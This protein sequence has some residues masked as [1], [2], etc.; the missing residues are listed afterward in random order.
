MRHK[1]GLIYAWFIRTM[2]YFLPD[3]PVIMRFRGW[4]YG[5]WMEQ[6]GHDFQVTHDAYIKDLDYLSVGNHVFVG[7]GTVIMGSGTITIEDEVMFAPHCIVISGNHVQQNGSFRYGKGDRGH[8]HIGRGSWV[9]GNS[10]IQRGSKL[11]PASVLSANSFLN[12]CYDEEGAL[13]GGVP[14]R[15]IKKLE[16]C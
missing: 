13:Y 16:I 5:L 14:A 15:F 7:N 11:P 1:F 6:C 12:K 3:I 4:C 8:I 10:T 9:A 2:L